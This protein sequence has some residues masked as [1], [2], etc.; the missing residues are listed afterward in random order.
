MTATIPIMIKE[1]PYIGLSFI[2]KETM[3]TKINNINTHEG[4]ALISDK[5]VF[6]VGKL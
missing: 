6:S 5:I 1:M 2:I 4:F 3:P